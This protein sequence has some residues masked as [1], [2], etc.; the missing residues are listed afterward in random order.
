MIELRNKQY[1]YI[2]DC[3]AS[4]EMQVGQLVRLQVNPDGELMLASPA[5]ALAHVSDISGPLFAYWI[6]DRSTAVA[7]EGGEDGLSF[8]LAT[9]DDAIHTIPVG[10][11]MLAVG[12]KGFAEIRFFESSLDPSLTG[13]LPAPGTVLRFAD[14]T[15]KLCLTGDLNAVAKDVALVVEND[16]ASISVL[17]G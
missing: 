7:F 13:A 17:V 6:N 4:V 5:T 1:A 9:G 15:S 3:V 8:P 16:G 11:R 12:G 14:D 10:K 2:I